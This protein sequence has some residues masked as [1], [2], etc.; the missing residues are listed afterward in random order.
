MT[1]VPLLDYLSEERWLTRYSPEQLTNLGAL[2]LFPSELGTTVSAST[3]GVF[4]STDFKPPVLGA[5]VQVL[6]IPEG[7]NWRALAAKLNIKLLDRRVFLSK[8]WLPL[9]PTLERKDQRV[10]LAWLRD[11][12]SALL[13]PDGIAD[14]EG[15]A[16][17]RT[18]R[19][20][21]LVLCTDGRLARG[22]RANAPTRNCDS[23]AP[24]R[25]TSSCRT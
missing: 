25:G 4:C 24:R 20:T 8:V 5:N 21:R 12:L 3:T 14:Q 22:A 16:I 11:N 19:E 7:R 17:R 2:P 6:S 1:H 18:L 13:L 23:G 15:D 9:Y 10:A